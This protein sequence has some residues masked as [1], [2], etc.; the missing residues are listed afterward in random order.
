MDKFIFNQFCFVQDKMRYAYK[1]G[2]WSG[3]RI[4]ENSIEPKFEP[5]PVGFD[6]IEETVIDLERKTLLIKSLKEFNAFQKDLLPN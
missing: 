6:P 2:N 5:L 4:S 1:N 3:A